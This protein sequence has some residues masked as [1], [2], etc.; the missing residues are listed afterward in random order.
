MTHMKKKKKAKPGQVRITADTKGQKLAYAK[1]RALVLETVQHSKSPSWTARQLIKKLKIANSKADVIRVLDAL[2]KQGKMNLLEEGVYASLVRPKASQEVI[3]PSVAKGKN[4]YTGR[5]DL[6]RSGAAYVIVDDLEDDIYV[7]ARHTAGAMHRDMVEVDMVPARKGRKPE[8][9]ILRV[10]KRALEQ[11]IG[12]LKLYK[13]FAVVVPDKTSIQF[14][15]IIPA[16]KLSEA[17]DGDKVVA[18]ITDWTTASPSGEIVHVL[19]ATGS[20]ELEMQSILIHNGFN[21]AWP[22]EVIEECLHLPEEIT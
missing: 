11:V 20:H 3:R 1:L 5:V 8:G 21:L 12:T 14:D 10:V 6:T 13:K 22:E 19:G 9:R 17:V 4:V 15:I 18:R 7:P 16:D 2:V